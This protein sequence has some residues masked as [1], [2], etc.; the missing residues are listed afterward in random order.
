MEISLV[1]I[2]NHFAA[3]AIQGKRER[4]EDCYKIC[5]T[6]ERAVLAVLA[7]GMGGHPGGAEAAQ[8]A[9]DAFV[10]AYTSASAK[11]NAAPRLSMEMLRAANR[12]VAQEAD[13]N[14]QLAG[15]GCTLIAA[16]VRRDMLEWISIGDSLLYLFSGGRLQKLNED[17]S[18]DGALTSALTGRELGE[19][20]HNT[21]AI[22]A[23]KSLVV[24]ASDGILTLD[25]AEIEECIRAGQKKD[26]AAAAYDLLA[27]TASRREPYQD[28]ATVVVIDPA[29]AQSQSFAL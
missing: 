27:E 17:H 8:L 15:M 13:N 6:A 19:V 21:A 11:T 4:Q 14:A 26:T 22:T 10:D 18:V 29:G 2:N 25:A 23:D 5:P 28:N 12:A 7:D 1:A 20:D 16:L 3:A 24:A 9:V